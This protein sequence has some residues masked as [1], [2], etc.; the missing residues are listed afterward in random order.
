MW[1]LWKKSDASPALWK[2]R[3][4]V[5]KFCGGV[6]PHETGLC[7]KLPQLP[8]T[9]YITT[10]FYHPLPLTRGAGGAKGRNTMNFS[11][12][13][14]LL[15]SAINTAGRTVAAKSSI[16]ALEGVLLEAGEGKLTLTG[17]N[18]ETGIETTIE[19]QVA[20]EGSLVLSP[21]L[22]GDI[23]RNLPDDMVTCSVQGMNVNI[24]C[25]LSDYNILGMPADEF[26]ELPSV[27]D[28]NGFFIP[29]GKLKAMIAQTIF[30][31]SDNESRPIHT[32]SLFE[33][34]GDELTVVSVDGYRLALRREKLTSTCGDNGFSFVVPGAALREVEKICTDCDVPV[35]VTQGKRHILFQTGNTVLISRR[36]E[37]E[38]LNYRQTIPQQNTVKVFGE[39]R[40]IQTCTDRVSLIISEK[41]KSPL[42]CTFGDGELS[43][44]T[45]TAIGDAFDSCSV[46]GNG[47]GLEIGFN[48]RY[49]TEA[50]RAAP[51][52]RVRLELNKPTS[53]CLIL[54]EKES[55]ESFL[56]MVLPVRLKAGE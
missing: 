11:C 28:G 7:G 24:K 56:Y 13:K 3:T 42:R 18:L 48:D 40:A 47:G 5:W 19:A 35:S 30:A 53:P 20:E 52:D 55:D 14:A 10:D 25:G 17:Y 16:A 29:Q 50:M 34:E 4:S 1:K 39:K 12:E 15:Q 8:Q 54:P 2:L 51:A 23:V 32:G 33:V 38:F 6:K 46:E 21:R 36:L 41:L 31:V 44:R 27:D 49:L 43:I 22:F 26:P 45:K 9:L 37:G